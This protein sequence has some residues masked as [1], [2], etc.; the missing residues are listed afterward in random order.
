MDRWSRIATGE[1]E[2]HTRAQ[3]HASGSSYARTVLRRL[4]VTFVS[5]NLALAGLLTI[6]P[7][8]IQWHINTCGLSAATVVSWWAIAVLGASVGGLLLH[9]YHTW[10]IRRGFAAWSALLRD[11]GE[12]DDS[13]TTVSSPSCRSLWLWI[14]LS[15]VV[16]V[17]V[18][19]LGAMGS[20]LAAGVR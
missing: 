1:P 20:V 18:A 5:T 14:L 19:A 15:Y 9:V 4:P 10:A 7:G 12:A 11:T 16:L 6:S 13:T 8:M 2:G 17:T 3:R